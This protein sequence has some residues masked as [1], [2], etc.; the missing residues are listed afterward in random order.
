MVYFWTETLVYFW[1]EIN[2][3]I[4]YPIGDLSK[5]AF[6]A[7]TKVKYGSVEITNKAW[8]SKYGSFTEIDPEAGQKPGFEY[9]NPSLIFHDWSPAMEDLDLFRTELRMKNYREMVAEVSKGM[10]GAAVSLRTEG[11]NVLIAGLSSQESNPRLRHI[12]YS[13]RRLGAIAEVIQK[14]NIIAVHSDYTTMPYSPS[15]LRMLTKKSIEQG[16]IPAYMPQ[17]DNMRDI[18]LNDKYGT[19]Y[20]WNLNLSETKKGTMMHVLTAVY[21]W[22]QA[23]YE[24]GGAPGI[25]WEDLQCDGFATVTQKA[26]MR[27]FKKKLEKV[28][29][30]NLE[31]NEKGQINQPMPYLT[32]GKR[33]YN[34]NIK[35]R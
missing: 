9:S 18:A 35:A 32:G 6:R 16:I 5:E 24:E 23:V 19:D 7:W 17:F 14:D 25:L 30:P 1:S 2:I 11:G 10:P 21:P 29:K 26:E 13:Q 27:L 28:F 3:Q 33:S 15:E 34:N 20:T 8:G 12:Y 31:N 22:F 4:R